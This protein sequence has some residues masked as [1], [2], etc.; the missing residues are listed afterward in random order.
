MSNFSERMAAAYGDRPALLD[1]GTGSPALLGGG[2]LTFR[3][4]RDATSRLA[5]TLI[6]RHDLKKGERV[7]IACDNQAHALAAFL[8]TVKAGG[9]AVP[10]PL[11][12]PP[13]QVAGVAGSARPALAVTDCPRFA[14][15]GLA[16]AWTDAAAG[17]RGVLTL[18]GAA[19]AAGGGTALEEGLASAG[20]L[21]MPYTMK[22]G[23]VPAIY[24]SERPAGLRGTMIANRSL[25]RATRVLALALAPCRGS[26]GLVAPEVREAAGLIAALAL[27]RSGRS[28]AFVNGTGGPRRAPVPGGRGAVFVGGPRAVEAWSRSRGSPDAWLCPGVR[29]GAAGAGSGAALELDGPVFDETCGWALLRARIRLGRRRRET[30]FLPLPAGRCRLSPEGRDTLEVKG[31]TVSFGYWMLLEESLQELEG[32]WFDT[33]LRAARRRPLGFDL[34]R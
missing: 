17:V 22:E 16:S 8:G 6:D 32:G 19:G 9:V 13:F 4:L 33:G 1:D 26:C 23:D 25:L 31:K 29:E 21:F 15:Q 24:F 12:L 30:P 14:G 27:L 7:L 18:G 2:V 28:V 34:L 5:F 10:L 20:D 11:R 3:G